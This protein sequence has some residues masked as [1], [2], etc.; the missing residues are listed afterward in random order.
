MTFGDNVLA[1]KVEFQGATVWGEKIA[2][3]E[4]HAV[5]MTEDGTLI[6]A[7]PEFIYDEILIG[8]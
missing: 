7:T 3:T 2:M 6:S 8:D 5:V 1:L 4:D